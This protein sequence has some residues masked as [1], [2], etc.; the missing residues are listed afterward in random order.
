[1]KRHVLDVNSLVELVHND[2]RLITGFSLR[3]FKM[4]LEVMDH[5][6]NHYYI[7]ISVGGQHRFEL[8]ALLQE[9]GERG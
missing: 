4:E 1:M 6:S 5:H 2:H 7:N 8:F 9:I 3:S